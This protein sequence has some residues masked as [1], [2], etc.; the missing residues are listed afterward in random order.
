MYTKICKGGKLVSIYEKRDEDFDDGEV[1]VTDKLIN[2]LRFPCIMEEGV[3]LVDILSLLNKNIDTMSPIL[4]DDCINV[5]TRKVNEH[6]PQDP[7]YGGLEC[8]ELGWF[9]NSDEHS[10]NGTIL[11]SFSAVYYHGKRVCVPML[12]PWFSVSYLSEIPIRLRNKLVLY[13]RAVKPAT[14]TKCKNPEYS[15]FCVLYGII[16][17]FYCCCTEIWEK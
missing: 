13:N 4:G 3:T 1:D 15:L 6:E 14:I 17:S 10:T 16:D 12:L 8:L 9:I 5:V 7:T 11:P 2:Y